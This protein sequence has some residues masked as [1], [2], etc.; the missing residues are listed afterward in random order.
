MGSDMPACVPVQLPPCTHCMG[1]VARMEP[2]GKVWVRGSG[3][4]G[5]GT[6]QS[7]LQTDSPEPARAI[8][9]TD[10]TTPMLNRLVLASIY[11]QTLG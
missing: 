8:L 1:T 2:W 10:S 6:L 9:G 4:V 5:F 3:G 11:P 7:V